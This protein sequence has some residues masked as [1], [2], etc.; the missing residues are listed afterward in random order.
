M[1]AHWQ[2]NPSGAGA[3]P[4][5]GDDGG[6]DIHTLPLQAKMLFPQFVH[7][8]SRLQRKNLMI[9]VMLNLIHCY[10]YVC[11]LSYKKEIFRGE[12]EKTRYNIVLQSLQKS[13]R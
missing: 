8:S 1:P 13:N 9:A 4:A 12:D 5:R 7:M 10:I 2:H 11:G 6:L 3:T